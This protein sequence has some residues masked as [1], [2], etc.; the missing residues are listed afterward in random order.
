MHSNVTVGPGEDVLGSDVTF[1]DVPSVVTREIQIQMYVG[2]SAI[3]SVRRNNIDFPINNG[4]P[5]TGVAT[6][7]ILMLN[8]DTLN[9][10]TNTAATPIEVIVAG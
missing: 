5:I 6:F 4:L 9:F 1:E 10:R 2:I 7:T 3:I 8:P